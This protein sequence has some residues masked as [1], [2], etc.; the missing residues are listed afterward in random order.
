MKRFQALRLRKVKYEE[1]CSPFLLVFGR[2]VSLNFTKAN[3]K[4]DGK[5]CE[6]SYIR[7]HGEFGQN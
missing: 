5:T 6:Y 7:I 2:E 4:K 1:T 3:P